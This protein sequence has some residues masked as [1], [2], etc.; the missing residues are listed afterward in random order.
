[1]ALLSPLFGGARVN[2]PAR[3]VS[4]PDSV[5]ETTV[6][7][8]PKKSGKVRLVLP[9][10]LILVAVA[11]VYLTPRETTGAVDQGNLVAVRRGRMVK[12]VVATGTIEPISNRLEIM[13]KA[14]GI[15][16]KIYA[17]VGDS[18]R[19][20]DVLVVLDRNYLLAQIREARAK[21]VA[22]E[23][24]LKASEAELDRHR[25]LAE[26]HEVDLARTETERMRALFADGLI[27]K[28][29]LDESEGRLEDALNKQ[30]AA[31]ALTRVT[32]AA[33][34]QKKAQI[35]QVEATIDRTQEELKFTT[36]RSPIDGVVL[37]RGS[38]YGPRPS[39]LEVGSAVSSILTMGEGATTVMTLGDM[40]K[41]YVKGQVTETDIGLVRDG[42]PAKITVEAFRGQEFVGEVYKISPF[43]L[44]QDAVTTFE[45]RVSVNNS[46]GLLLANMSANAEI[47]L[48]EHPDTLVIPEG[49]LIYDRDQNTFV[50]VPDPTLAEGKRREQVQVGISDGAEAE[51]LS[52][53]H[54]GQMILLQ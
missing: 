43:G 22:S 14:S 19:K 51:I 35:T 1:M 13:S 32:E 47:I 21:L 11:Y 23:A 18:V 28:S 46:E 5:I 7:P 25:I 2:G 33:I 39:T 20:G 45:V 49:A 54:Q 29:E 40:R 10:L 44:E 16:E 41:V 4:K 27:A 9:L 26:G 15:V 6:P 8:V 36:I 42:L 52:G 3:G 48:E 37:A 50:E 31:V 34:A 38:T 17:D 30:R 24:D 12:S 53:L